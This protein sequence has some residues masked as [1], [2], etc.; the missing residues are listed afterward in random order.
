MLVLA[1]VGLASCNDAG[2]AQAARDVAEVVAAVVIVVLVVSVC[3]GAFV[4]VSVVGGIVTSIMNVIGPS[5]RTRVWGLV[6]GST[7]ALFGV[8][9]LVGV[10]AS[11]PREAPSFEPPPSRP[12][13]EESEG[14][15]RDVLD[16]ADPRLFEPDPYDT[17]PTPAPPPAAAP[18]PPPV[19]LG[20]LLGGLA[21]GGFFL[22][23]GGAG[24]FTAI[25]ARVPDAAPLP[26]RF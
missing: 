18:T 1:L 4:L 15:P 9:G 23:L 17:A 5:R 26:A 20:G 11:P 6:F 8:I 19:D 3:L 12:V 22:L 13:G 21:F 24:L 14:I 10:V 16:P 25:R 7:N 2:C